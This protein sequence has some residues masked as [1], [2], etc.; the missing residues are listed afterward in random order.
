VLGHQPL[1]SLAELANVLRTSGA[2]IEQY[3]LMGDVV[4]IRSGHSLDCPKLLGILGGSVKAGRVLAHLSEPNPETLWE[5]LISDSVLGGLAESAKPV[6]LAISLYSSLPEEQFPMAQRRS[7]IEETNKRCK[8]FLAEKGVSC[9]YLIWEGSRRAEPIASAQLI[10]THTLE[11]GAEICLVWDEKGLFIGKTEAVQE[12][13]AFAKRD[14]HKPVRRTTEGLLP[15]KLA[16]ILVNLCR[17]LEDRMLLD[18]FCGSGV[19]LLEALQLGL[20]VIGSDLASE[21][22]DAS[23]VNVH[24]LY[25]QD[26]T[27]P[28]SKGNAFHCHDARRLTERIAPLSVDC[29]AT[30]P[31]LG[32]PLRRPAN[33]LE[34]ARLLSELRHLYVEALAELR[35]LLRPGGRLCVIL[36]RLAG[37][38]QGYGLDLRDEIGLMGYRIVSPLRAVAG[39][40]EQTHLLYARHDQRVFR[41]IWLLES[42]GQER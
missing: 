33:P 30:E 35:I 34:A 29:I 42:P 31:Y 5:S 19:I 18:P 12:L 7:V 9:R 23:Q 36:P 4:V 26:P 14:M 17:Q 13:D 10:K 1:L 3:R 20:N 39:F 38:G 11:S 37:P 27:L 28:D 22:V 32:P 6:T 8:K 15:P 25:K 41:E 24:W 21:A 40:F 16:R 2:N